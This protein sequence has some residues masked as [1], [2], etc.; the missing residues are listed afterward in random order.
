MNLYEALKMEIERCEELLVAY[1]AI[2]QGKFAAIMIKEKIIKAKESI[3][4]MNTVDMLEL[5]PS[6]KECQ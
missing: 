6:L 2:P 5:Y 4:N 1:E 3:T